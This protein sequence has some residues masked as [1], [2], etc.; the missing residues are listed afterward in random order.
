VG[1]ESA[2]S[3]PPACIEHGVVSNLQK[4]R[5]SSQR[6]M[7][8]TSFGGGG[9][10]SPGF[11]GEDDQIEMALP[12]T[13]STSA[14]PCHLSGSGLRALESNLPSAVTFTDSSPFVGA[15]QLPHAPRSG[16][17]HPPGR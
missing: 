14:R 2:G 17:R 3:A 7:Q 15:A 12:A 10:R 5:S 4:S 1:G 8:L 16:H 11:L 6:R 13:L 9:G